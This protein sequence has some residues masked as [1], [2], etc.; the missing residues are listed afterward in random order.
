VKGGLPAVV[1]CSDPFRQLAHA[2]MRSQN[3]ADALAIEIQGNPETFDDATLERVS[4]EVLQAVVG[5][6]LR[7]PP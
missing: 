1:V 7:S 2:I 6:L 5:K 4:G 3:V